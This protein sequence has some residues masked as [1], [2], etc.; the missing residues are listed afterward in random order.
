M[1]CGKIENK[2]NKLLSGEVAS[3]LD[4]NDLF[5]QFGQVSTE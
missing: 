1:E 4:F 2:A 3:D 5:D